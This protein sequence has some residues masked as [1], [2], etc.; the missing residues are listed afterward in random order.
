MFLYSGDLKLGFQ[1]EEESEKQLLTSI[2][3]GRRV[4][5]L[6]KK[7]K[8]YHDDDEQVQ[9]TE[10]MLMLFY[11]LRYVEGCEEDYWLET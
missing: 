9:M 4:S 8:D 7:Q 2:L 3:E 6:V 5:Q 11:G 10:Q 1:I